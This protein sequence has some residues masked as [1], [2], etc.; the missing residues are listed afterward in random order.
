MGAARGPGCSGGRE[1]G[2]RALEACE[3]RSLHPVCSAGGWA[4]CQPTAPE[5]GGCGCL[6]SEPSSVE[7][8]VGLGACTIHRDPGLRALAWGG[9]IG[10]S[11]C[12]GCVLALPA[13]RGPAESHCGQGCPLLRAQCWFPHPVSLQGECQA[14][15]LAVTSSSA[16]PLPPAG[17]LFVQSVHQRLTAVLGC[18]RPC[19]DAVGWDFGLGTVR[20]VLGSLMVTWGQR[21][22]WNRVPGQRPCWFAPGGVWPQSCPLAPSRAGRVSGC[23]RVDD[24][25]FQPR[26][27]SS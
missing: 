10:A 11:M 23:V 24:I 8:G 5:D 21:S 22:Q 6:S 13:Q 15:A 7:L 2:G 9:G 20:R 16:E 17:R 12:C 3:C 26:P 4:Q 1:G 25:A 27:W 14:V 18:V 19:G